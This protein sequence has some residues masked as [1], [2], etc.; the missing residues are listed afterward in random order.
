M[1]GSN[2]LKLI[3]PMALAKTL[4]DIAK[5]VN[6]I[7]LFKT[8][9]NMASNIEFINFI[10]D[11]GVEAFHKIYNSLKDKDIQKFLFLSIK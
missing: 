8:F 6:P 9:G 5:E 11:A 10:K 1:F 7:I 2:N 3:N 4:G